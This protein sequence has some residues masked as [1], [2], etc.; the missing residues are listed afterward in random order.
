MRL[1]T[2]TSRPSTTRSLAASLGHPNGFKVFIQ[3]LSEFLHETI[4]DGGAANDLVTSTALELS[5]AEVWSKISASEIAAIFANAPKQTVD[6]FLDGIPST[7]KVQLFEEN[8]KWKLRKVT[9]ILKAYTESH[10]VTHVAVPAAIS[11]ALHNILHIASERKYRM[12]VRITQAEAVPSEREIVYSVLEVDHEARENFVFLGSF[13]V[14][15]EHRQNPAI[16][17]T[18]PLLVDKLN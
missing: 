17:P 16:N 10:P 15:P 6:L 4:L 12:G 18:A 1:V 11:P 13:E 2:W 8:R 9:D 7:Y 3:A 5:A 14:D